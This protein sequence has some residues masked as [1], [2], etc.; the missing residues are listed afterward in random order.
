M[1]RVR[2]GEHP[3]YVYGAMNAKTMYRISLNSCGPTIF[4]G[5]LYP[6]T[7]CPL[8]RDRNDRYSQDSTDTMLSVVHSLAPALLPPGSRLSTEAIRAT[9]NL[10]LHYKT[11][12]CQPFTLQWKTWSKE[13]G[14]GERPC[15]QTVVV[16]D[17]KS[18]RLH[19]TGLTL[20][21]IHPSPQ[22]LYRGR[23]EWAEVVRESGLVSGP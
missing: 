17:P 18:R 21:E 15:P 14:F 11:F 10:V 7:E 9:Y 20:C 16:F 12:F 6:E 23:P 8:Y 5:R 1:R 2:P 4:V 3:L 19:D 13:T 22:G